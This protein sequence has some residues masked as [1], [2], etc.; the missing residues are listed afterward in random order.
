MSTSRCQSCAANTLL[1][2]YIISKGKVSKMISKLILALLQWN[3]INFPTYFS[4]IKMTIK[5]FT[6]SFFLLWL[7]FHKNTFV[8]YASFRFV[9]VSLVIRKKAKKVESSQVRRKKVLM[10]DCN[11]LWREGTIWLHVSLQPRKSNFNLFHV[12]LAPPFNV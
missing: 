4:E 9:E 11:F 6:I 5:S 1:M 7:F 12:F 2:L 10:S 3:H 8:V